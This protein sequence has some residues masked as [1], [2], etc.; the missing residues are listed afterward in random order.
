MQN[1]A[2]TQKPAANGRHEGQAEAIARMQRAILRLA[3]AYLGQNKELDAKLREL[4]QL[5]RSGRR[6]NDRQPLIDQIVDNIINLDL[7][8]PGADE[9]GAAQTHASLC[10][11]LRNLK[12]PETLVPEIERAERELSRIQDA[13]VAA[14]RVRETALALSR[15]LMQSPETCSDAPAIRALL[16]DLL[17]QL[18]LPAECLPELGAV[19]ASVAAAEDVSSFVTCIDGI[20][21][22]VTSSRKA[23][24]RQIEHLTHYLADVAG[25]LQGFEEYVSETQKHSEENIEH[26]MQLSETMLHEIGGLRDASSEARSLDELREQIDTRLGRIGDGLEKFVDGQRE[27]TVSAQAKLERV[28]DQLRELESQTE[29][30]REDLEQEQ[31]RVVIDP[32][33]SVLNRRGYEEMGAKLFARWKRYGGALSLAVIDLDLFKNINDRFGHTA[34]DRVLTT[35]AGQIKSIIRN[36]DVLCRYGGEEFVLLLPETSADQACELIEKIRL[37]IENCPFR[38]KDTPVSVTFS[39]GVAGFAPDDDFAAAFE[40]ADRAMYAAKQRGRNQTCM[41]DEPLAATGTDG[42]AG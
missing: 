14:R 8:K 21:G 36:S 34:G 13:S 11:F 17:D 35:V 22:L 33:T 32:L 5:I 12:A 10:E 9:S 18:E 40:R 31:A 7:K 24:E 20:T 2:Q 37:H 1:S 26:A 19:R 27:R 3:L 4:G 38:H 15:H 41:G 39:A 6:Q 29:N 30:L 25:R 23:L 42:A 16:E 28:T